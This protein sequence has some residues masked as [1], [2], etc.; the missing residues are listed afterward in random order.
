MQEA[1]RGLE[2]TEAAALQ[3]ALKLK[4]LEAPSLTDVLLNKGSA[5]K[6]QTYLEERG[7]LAPDVAAPLVRAAFRNGASLSLHGQAGIAVTLLT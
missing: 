1:L 4:R 3:Q 2:P 7:Q 5:D 6:A